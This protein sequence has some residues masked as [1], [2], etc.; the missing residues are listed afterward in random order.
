M[1]RVVIYDPRRVPPN[2]M[3]LLHAE[4]FAV[5]FQDVRTSVGLNSEGSPWTAGEAE[6]CFVFDSLTEAK[7]FCHELVER[8]QHVRCN[9][10]DE[11]GMAVEPLYTIVNKRHEMKVGDGDQKLQC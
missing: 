8:A 10:F 3:H 9:I 7:Q 5:F 6:S 4:Q 1:Q 2:W 11:R